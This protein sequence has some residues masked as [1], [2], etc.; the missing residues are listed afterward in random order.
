MLPRLLPYVLAAAAVAPLRGADAPS[1][2]A[3]DVRNM[4]LKVKPSDDFNRFANG[5]WLDTHPIPPD[6]VSWGAFDELRDRN[7]G[8]LRDIA[9]EASTKSKDA[10]AGSRL[11]V[12]GDFYAS[13]MNEA[14]LKSEGAK[15]LDP[16]FA[17]IA[18]V[19]DAAG[20]AALF[21]HLRQ[22]GADVGFAFFGG[23]DAKD[24]TQVIGQFAQAGLGLPDRDYYVKDD[25]DSVKLREGYQAHIAKM[26]ALLGDKPEAAADAAKRIVT[27]ETALA[28]ASR[29][30][31]Q[32]RDREANYNKMTVA[33]LTALVPEFPLAK[34]IES[35][36]PPPLGPVNVGQPDF[37]KAFNQLVKERPLADW[38]DYARW[39]LLRAAA[40]YLSDEFVQ[41]DFEF[42]G[43]TVTGAKQLK[44]RWKRVV[45]SMDTG[46]GELLGQEYV[47]KTFPP[48]AKQ[49]VLA[50]VENLRAALKERIEQLDWMTPAT[51]QAALKKLAA[52]GVKMGYPDK[53]RDYS[54]LVVDRGP[55]V[56]NVLRA[57]QHEYKRVVSRIGQPVDRTEWGMTPP[58]VNAYYRSSLNE[59]VFP[60]GILQP[61]F[62][63]LSADD[64]VNYGGI[65]AVIGHEMTH[66]FDDQGRKSDADG[67]LKDWWAPEDAKAYNER[68]RRVIEQFNAYKVLD[69][70]SVNGELTQ[71]ENIADLGGLKVAY[72]A[73]QKA[74]AAKPVAEREKKIDGFTPAQRFFLGYATLWRRNLTPENTRLRIKTDPHSPAALRVNGPL[75]NMPEFAAAFNV[76]PGSPMARPESERAAIW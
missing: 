60:A 68:A 36:Q 6:L 75:S 55:Y 67:N 64:A 39:H 57:R 16:E 11:R 69:G 72:A 26:L 46:I 76:P 70:L 27:L 63:S 33:E 10:P 3:I 65:G 54:K 71:G 19:K 23:Q 20:L 43:R 17:R 42:Y 47:A 61:P 30:R 49:R 44:P 74:Q 40:P 28:K 25:A 15:P 7:V 51:K 45:E 5:G 35:A 73:F 4:D 52:F 34:F 13:G 31:V 32:R 2:A 8:I 59:I 22:L 48:E 29:T 38:K 18:A 66:G 12:I 58:T 24:S 41:A 9:S 62:F 14:Q 1:S 21:G 37:M 50:L 53:W 56:L